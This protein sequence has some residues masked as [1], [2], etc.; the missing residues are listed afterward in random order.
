MAYHVRITQLKMHIYILK[1][2]RWNLLARNR[3]G[4]RK[5]D[6]ELSLWSTRWQGFL[7]GNHRHLRWHLHLH[8]RRNLNNAKRETQLQPHK[9][10]YTG[11]LKD[12]V[13]SKLDFT[14]SE[15]EVKEQT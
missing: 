3:N 7:G 14:V 11:M 12:D 15:G 4:V 9:M 5:F 1:L 13:T 2:I 10:T 8:F 6:W